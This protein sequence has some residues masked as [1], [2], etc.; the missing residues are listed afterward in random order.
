M[1]LVDRDYLILEEVGRW[2][3]VL[4]RHLRVLADFSGE[5]ACDR[6]LRTLIEAG[7]LER[8]KYIYGVPSLYSLTSNGKKLIQINY[9]NTSVKL[10]QVIH[11]IAVVDTAIYYTKK[12][13]VKLSDIHTEKQLHITDGFGNRKHQPDFIFT[14]DNKKYC[15]EVELSQKEKSRLTKNIKDNYM[16]FDFQNWIIPKN[17]V[18]IYE[19]VSDISKQYNNV[20]IL[21]L[22]V[23]QEFVKQ[24]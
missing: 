9:R 16:N 19:M 21:D 5:R 18:K 3:V 23:V 11:D 7:Y 12:E 22:E 6:R 1:R 24:L 14:K 8:K 20:Q 4:G 17:K 2:R 10:D 15:I 13:N